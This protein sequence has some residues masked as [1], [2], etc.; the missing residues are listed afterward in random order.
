MLIASHCE[1][2]TTI[3]ENTAKYR[4]EYGDNIPIELHPVIR[5]EDACYISS[6]F[7]SELAREHG[8]RLHILHISTAKEIGLFD[9]D[10]PLRE[11]KVT[12]EAC[13][14]HMWF[15]DSLYPEKGTFIKWNPAIKTRNDRDAIL[16]G[17]LDDKID[18]I[19]TDHAPHTREEKMNDYMHAPSGGPLVQHSLNVMMEFV[20]QGKI[21]IE[22]VVEKMCHNPAILFDVRERGYIREG[23]FADLVIV[24]PQ[25][26]WTVRE[27]NILAKCGWSPFE[28]QE[29]SSRVCQTFISGHLAYTDGK[30]DESKMG[31][32]LE[33]DPR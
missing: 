22:R 4:Q 2:E 5:S 7:A 33:F 31:K 21:T 12:S 18:V 1:D 30:F 26:S 9:N 11:K 15:D 25:D 29:F 6:S 24:D 28:G 14:H 10:I 8:T 16:Q 32:R 23:Y 19:A 20:K 13:V 17:V 3:R 27:E